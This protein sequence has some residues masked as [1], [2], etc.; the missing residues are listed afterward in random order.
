MYPELMGQ[1]VSQPSFLSAFSAP[2]AWCDASGIVMGHN[3]AFEAWAGHSV[4]TRVAI[5]G[6]TGTIL[7]PDHPPRHLV[8][9][10]LV[11]GSWLALGTYVEGPGVVS[12]V[13]AAVALRLERVEGSLAAN[14]QLGLLDLPNESVARCLRENLAAVEEIRTL[15]LQVAALGAGNA[16]QRLP[17]CLDLLVRNAAAAVR[18]LVVQVISG[19]ADHTVEVDRARLFPILVGLLGELGALAPVDHPLRVE[20]RGGDFVRLRLNVTTLPS[21]HSD[22]IAAARRFVAHAGGRVLIEPGASLTLELPAFARALPAVGG[23]GSGGAVRGTVLIAD[24]DESALAMMGAV[25]RRAGFR[26]LAAEDGVAA[27]ALFRKHIS[28]IVAIVADAVLPGR[29]G[30]ELAAEAR[31][32]AP[33]L[34]VLL[35]SGHASDLMGAPDV[36]DLPI[37]SKPFGA[38]VLAERLRDLLEPSSS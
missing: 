23:A 6:T 7:A 8:M 9:S 38:R 28:E 10:P 36:C 19:D 3:A 11:D 27:S 35:I 29:S 25:L 37:L 15:R 20:L 32:S 34:P 24:D 22:T 21:S 1:P 12:A 26:V 14:A 30:V 4:G 5:Y 17:V 13:T 31:R 16:N 2:A 18:P 33:S